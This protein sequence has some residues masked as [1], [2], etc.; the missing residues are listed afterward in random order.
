M[1]CRTLDLKDPNQRALKTPYIPF[2]DDVDEL[3]RLIFHLPAPLQAVMH[4]RRCSTDEYVAFANTERED[5]MRRH[6]D[7]GVSFRSP[8]LGDC[9]TTK[10]CFI[11]LT[12]FTPYIFLIRLVLM[13]AT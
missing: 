3:V 7:L 13:D 9:Y 11:S 5:F 8:Y 1:G 4:T 12:I 2:T 10:P 6:H